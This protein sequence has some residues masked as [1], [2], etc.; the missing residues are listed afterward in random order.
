[1]T[2]KILSI[3]SVT[4]RKSDTG[5]TKV[6]FLDNKYVKIVKFSHGYIAQIAVV[7]IR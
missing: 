7:K 2:N 4:L 6:Y 1:M 3:A 5:D